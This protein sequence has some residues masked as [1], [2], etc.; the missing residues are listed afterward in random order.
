MM[1]RASVVNLV[2]GVTLAVGAISGAPALATGKVLNLKASGQ[3]IQA[4]V[5][6]YMQGEFNIQLG[7]SAYHCESDLWGPMAINGAKTDKI[8]IEHATGG[9]QGEPSWCQGASVNASGFPWTF[10]L[11]ANGKASLAGIVS[12]TIEGCTYTAKKLKG[13]ESRVPPNEWLHDT[14]SGTLKTKSPS[15]S[16]KTL[17]LSA[18]QDSGWYAWSETVHEIVHMEA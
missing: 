14:L 9:F 3:V 16:V 1:R 15:C 11:G 12:L 4:G 7:A 6:S 5:N 8:K 13:V 17:H 18:E 2:A 10:N